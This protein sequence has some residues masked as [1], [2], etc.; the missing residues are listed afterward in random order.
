MN[1]PSKKSVV[2][3]L[4]LVAKG[5]LM[6]P[7]NKIPGVSGGII[8]LV[9][10][11]YHKLIQSFQNL[12]INAFNQILNFQFKSFWRYINGSFLSLVFGGVVISYFSV[13][14]LLDYLF[15]INEKRKLNIDK[16]NQRKENENINKK[17][18]DAFKCDIC[19]LWSTGKKCNNKECTNS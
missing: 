8:A 16:N 18:I 10:C 19:G 11:C 17:G 15:K 2:D 9:F 1:L 3:A 6:G 5:I 12:N 13:S 14:L 7:A 4:V